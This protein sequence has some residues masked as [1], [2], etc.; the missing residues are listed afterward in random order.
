MVYIKDILL[1]TIAISGVLATP[2]VKRDTATPAAS[3][4]YALPSY[5]TPVRPAPNPSYYV[6]PANNTDFVVESLEDFGKQEDPDNPLT[7]YRDGGGSCNIGNR[8]IWF[9]CDTLGYDNGTFMAMTDNSLSVAQ[10]FDEP[11]LLADAT[12]NSLYSYGWQP[13]VP[14][15]SEEY[16]WRNWPSQRFTLWTYTNCI[17]TTATQAV[18]FFHVYKSNSYTS[19]SNWG[20]TMA[21]LN[22]DPNTNMLT[23]SRNEQVAFPNTTY[24]YGSFASIPEAGTSTSPESP[25]GKSHSTTSIS[26]MMHR[27]KLGAI[28]SHNPRHGANRRRSCRIG[29]RIRPGPCSTPNTTTR[30]SS[31][32]STTGQT[33]RSKC[34]THRVLSGPGPRIIRFFIL[35]LKDRVDMITVAS[36][37]YSITKMTDRREKRYCSTIR[38][39]TPRTH[40]QE[41]RN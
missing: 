23:I 19:S 32:I 8:T 11:S 34:R 14:Y 12:S 16:P 26:I 24:S 6:W 9:F 4:S 22:L 3:V 36:R 21:I 25:P 17:Q 10:S 33:R 31:S 35:Y 7:I 15:T 39:R 38:T 2:V 1:A 29:Y 5:L 41:R 40:I 18:Q 30:T 20:N 13:A 28:L 37:M 27:Q